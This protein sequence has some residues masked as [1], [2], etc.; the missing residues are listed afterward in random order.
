MIFGQISLK[1]HQSGHTSQSSSRLTESESESG[2]AEPNPCP[3]RWLGLS[4]D[5]SALPMGVS[6][7]LALL[8][9][10][11]DVGA[12]VSDRS[13]VLHLHRLRIER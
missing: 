1:G 12:R 10:R 7:A 8:L 11:A 9:T 5:C 4:I 3:G 13:R 2:K 6:G